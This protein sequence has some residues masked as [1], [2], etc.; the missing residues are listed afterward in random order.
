[1]RLPLDLLKLPVALVQNQRQSLIMAFSNV[2][3]WSIFGIGL[4]DK[5]VPSPGES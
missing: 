4:K 1:M 2:Y 3:G 5:A